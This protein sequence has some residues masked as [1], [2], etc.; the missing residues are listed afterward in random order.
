MRERACQ[1]S[2]FS[3][4]G[5]KK[6][7]WKKR[8]KKKTSSH[9]QSLNSSN[10][11]ELKSDSHLKIPS[12]PISSTCSP[13]TRLSTKL[14]S[15]ESVW[16]TLLDVLIQDRFTN[17]LELSEELLVVISKLISTMILV[18]VSSRYGFILTFFFSCSLLTCRYP[19]LVSI[20]QLVAIH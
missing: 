5:A 2:S 12:D 1:I 16:L 9:S 20:H 19:S 8:G 3:R 4:P 18:V 15:T 6:N 10:P 13:C 7:E 17:L 11:R 14:E